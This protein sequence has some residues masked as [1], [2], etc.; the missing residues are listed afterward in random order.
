MN[1]SRVLATAIEPGMRF[2]LNQRSRRV[3]VDT[4]RYYNGYVVLGYHI[5]GQGSG[6]LHLRADCY[7]SATR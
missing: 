1:Q 5:D 2:M 4:A 6:E 3:T 7:L